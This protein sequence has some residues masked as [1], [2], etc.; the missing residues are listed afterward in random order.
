MLY[1]RLKKAYWKSSQYEKKPLI[2]RKKCLMKEHPF[3]KTVSH[4]MRGDLMKPQSMK[5]RL[6]YIALLRTFK[7]EVLLMYLR[8]NPLSVQ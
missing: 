4:P 6:L 3:S 2:W 7:W 8:L 1:G 5:S